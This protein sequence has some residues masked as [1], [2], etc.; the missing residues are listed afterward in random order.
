MSGLDESDD[1]LDLDVA[2]R[3]DELAGLYGEALEADPGLTPEAFAAQHPDVPRDALLA[4]LHGAGV[5]ARAARRSEG[6]F[7]TGARV[8]PYRI[9]G[10]I[11]RGG[12][13]IVYDAVEEELGRAVALKA[14]DAIRVDDNT[15]AR[16]V[17]EARAAARLD[18]SGIVPVFGSGETDGVLWYAMRRVQGTSL[19]ALLSDVTSS[20]ERRRD[21]ARST[22][23]S[24]VS[25]SGSGSASGSG[26]G[27][28]SRVRASVSIVKRLADALAYAHGS[29]I[30]HRDIKPANVLLDDSGAPLLTDFGLCK[31]D[32]DGSLTAANDLVGTLRYMPPEALEGAFDV[33][34]DVY[35]LGLVL[36][37]LLS[38]RPAFVSDSR[39]TMLHQV[40]RVEPAALAKVAPQVPPDVARVVTKAISKLPEERYADAASFVDDLEALLSGRAVRA[41]PASALYLARLFVRRNRGLSATIAAALIAAVVGTAAYVVQLRDANERVNEALQASLRSET[42]ARIA[43]AEATLEVHDLTR[44]RTLLDGVAPEQ[45]DW[46]WEHLAARVGIERTPEVIG[47]SDPRKAIQD[48]GNRILVAYGNGGMAAFARE[49]LRELGRLDGVFLSGAIGGDGRDLYL[50]R[51]EPR[52][53]IHVRV[54]DGGLSEPRVVRTMAS[55]EYELAALEGTDLVF[56]RRAL[57]G[58]IAI[59]ATSGETVWDADYPVDEI[60]VFDALSEDEVVLGLRGG[61]V[62][63]IKR[64]EKRPVQVAAH[65][66]NASAIL[67]VDGEVMATGSDDGSVIVHPALSGHTQGFFAVG[68]A[69]EGFSLDR[70]GTGLLAATLWDRTTVLLRPKSGG[71][72][73]I[74]SSFAA[75][76]LG[77]GFGADPWLVTFTAGGEL[78]RH[79]RTDHD[80]RI[81]LT[82]GLGDLGP[83]GVSPDGRRVA[84]YGTDWIL[85]LHDLT[86]GSVRFTPI[87]SRDAVSPPVFHPGGELLAHGRAVLDLETFEPRHMAR[88]EKAIVRSN[89]TA[90]GALIAISYAPEPAARDAGAEMTLLR[91]DG[92]DEEGDAREERVSLGSLRGRPTGLVTAGERA[93]ISMRYGEVLCI[94]VPTLSVA[95]R[96]TIEGGELETCAFDEASGKLY[97]VARDGL[98]RVLD[99]ASGAQDDARSWRVSTAN[100]LQD[101]VVSVA[102]GP[103]P[104][105]LTTCTNDGRV[106]VWEA[107]SGRRLGALSSNGSWLKHVAPLGDTGWLVCA[108]YFGRIDLFGSGDVPIGGWP[109]FRAADFTIEDVAEIY[110]DVEI[111]R[112]KLL[113][114]AKRSQRFRHQPSA[115][116]G[117]FEA[118]KEK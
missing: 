50:S 47:L 25:S 63:R 17:R 53:L 88:F 48:E 62:Y 105:L 13:G 45:R 64:G 83:L 59:D 97:V 2:V 74:L 72:E 82:P 98:V 95:W 35:S 9:R 110:R 18:H 87:G 11:G 52:E 32:D 38:G 4:V 68:G 23:D 76:P 107:D 39:Q 117:F 70:E 116:K 28:P 75:M 78:A 66:G 65:P 114:A 31:V 22:L 84:T 86:D 27:L 44:A 30:L 94:D 104:G 60:T 71:Y 37:E 103:E 69:V 55:N 118:E 14:M 19:D 41:R 73:R 49:G 112:P 26:A 109:A 8:G 16:F 92:L 1:D 56:V 111:M 5:L 85:Y 6:P 40:L 77:C 42:S 106:R 46:M 29:G 3:V 61:D 12:M 36:Y 58:I 81:A 99:G 113:A 100:A 24:A 101:R 115:W 20:D 15:R 67:V 79:E 93:Y 96:T 34:G 90:S 91:V 108:G 102:T 57:N 33:R 21:R 89:F 80:G 7:E 51:F 43:G 10:V 54:E